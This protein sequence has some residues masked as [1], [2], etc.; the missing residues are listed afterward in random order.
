MDRDDLV[1]CSVLVKSAIEK[2][3]DKIHLPKNS[4]DVLAQ[5]IIGFA[6]YDQI[7]AK[8]LYILVR[9]SYSYHSLNWSDFESVLEYLAGHFTS[10]EDRHVYAKIW[11]DK[12]TGM[13]GRR[14]KMTRVIYMTNLGT[15]PEE[16]YMTV[17]IGDQVMGKIDEAFLERLKPGDIFVLGGEVYEFKYAS[18]MTCQVRS[19]ANRPPTVPSWFSEMLPLSY[20]LAMEIGRLRRLVDEKFQKKLSRKEIA[21]FLKEFLYIDDETTAL[22]LYTY[23]LEQHEFS[24]IPSDKKITLEHF[25]E[26]EFNYVV[27]HTLFGRRVNDCLSRATAYVLGKQQHVDVEVGISDNGFYLCTPKNANVLRAF[28]ALKPEHLRHLLEDSL[29][30]SEVLNRRFRHCACRALMILREY[31]GQRK[32]V[33]RQQMGSRILLSAVKRISPN[34]SILKEARR[35]VLEDLMDVENTLKV[36]TAIENKQIQ[37]E[38]FYTALPSP[39]AF[40]MVTEGYSDIIRMED[41]QEFLKRMHQQVLAKIALKKGKQKEPIEEGFDYELLWEKVEKSLKEEKI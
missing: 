36:L 1:E 8:E 29:E 37:V 34:F 41:K 25:K 40:G 30:K 18:G 15:I 4:L 21:Q 28:K 23:F 27:F 5:Q 19:S 31:K 11:Y 9:N 26:K 3:I 22:A 24:A 39:F 16:T 35:E 32:Q 13:L 20:D 2:K 10:L 7:S 17:K 14:G 38:E 12:E 33:G 6:L